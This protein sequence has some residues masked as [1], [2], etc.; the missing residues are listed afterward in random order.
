MQRTFQPYIHSHHAMLSDEQQLA[1][2]DATKGI[3][4]LIKHAFGKI[5]EVGQSLDY[6]IKQLFKAGNRAIEF[7]FSEVLDFLKDDPLQLRILLLLE[8]MGRPLLCRHITDVLGAEETDIQ[9]RIERLTN[10]HC[11]F[12]LVTGQDVKFAMADEART[13]SRRIV[14]D[15]PDVARQV[16]TLMER[17]SIDQRMDYSAEEHEASL[18]FQRYVGQKQYL[19]AEDFMKEK[20]ASK[21]DSILLNLAYAKYLKGN[22]NRI[23]E[24]IDRLEGIRA[25]SGHAKE[26]LRL[27]MKYYAEAIPP[28]YEQAQVYARELEESVATDLGLRFDI[29]EFHVRWSVYLKMGFDIDPLHMKLRIQKYKELAAE[30]VKLLE[31]AG[32]V[33]THE[34]YY[35]LAQAYYNLWN[36]DMALRNIGSAITHLPRGSNDIDSYQVLRSEILKKKNTYDR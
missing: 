14:Y 33:N 19:A 23:K 4:L 17:L 30:A 21:P 20:L 11:V 31:G 9:E 12:R 26:I 6:V 16:R 5:Y 18:E 27:L 2:Y 7:S 25:R 35:L 34:K 15:N 36:Y 13:F 8:L 32:G 28:N 10:Y 1:L 29:A 22:K 3:P 24:A